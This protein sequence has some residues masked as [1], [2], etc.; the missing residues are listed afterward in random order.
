MSKIKVL[1]YSLLSAPILAENIIS[2]AVGDNISK[3]LNA[4]ACACIL[5]LIIIRRKARFDG[6]IITILLLILLHF[7]ITF[8]TPVTITPVNN[9][10]TPYGLIG[11]LALFLLIDSCLNK[12]SEAKAVFLGASIVLT[13]SVVVNLLFTGNLHIADN[14]ATFKEAVRTGYTMSRTW[15]FGHRNMICIYHLLWIL[16]MKIYY[17]LVNKKYQKMFIF[18]ILFTLLIGVISWNSTMIFVTILILLLN[19][20]HAKI[21]SKIKLFHYFIVYLAIEFGVVF[22]RVQNLFSYFIVT[23]LHRNLSFTGRA[24]IWDYYINQFTS[25][26]FFNK[27][28]GN[29]GYTELSVNTHNMMLGLL[30]FTGLVGCVLYFI[31]LIFAIKKLDKK[32][33]DNDAKFFSTIIFGFLINS[34]MMEFYLQPLLA[35]Y[36]GTRYDQIKQLASEN[37]K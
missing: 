33:I 31:T 37:E 32:K 34:L 25:G 35:I 20:F 26:D 15:L 5:L 19:M 21:F 17:M 18:Q 30:T 13:I 9:L 3:V 24:G 2:T 1:L 14:I 6:F 23:V 29:L 8:L 12:K 4:A 16:F 7:S 36:L 27:L 11:Y 10:I 28:F 22:L